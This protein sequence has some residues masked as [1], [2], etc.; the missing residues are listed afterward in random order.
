M[1]LTTPPARQ[2]LDTQ[3]IL[4]TGAQESFSQPVQL[5]FSDFQSRLRE[6]KISFPKLVTKTVSEENLLGEGKEAYVYEI[7]GIE[8]YVLRVTH[9]KLNKELDMYEDNHPSMDYAQ[10]I[11]G[12]YHFSPLTAAAD[13][14]PHLNVGQA[15]GKSK[16]IK[17]LKKQAGIELELPYINDQ[18]KRREAHIWLCKQLANLP[19]ESYIEFWTNIKTLDELKATYDT[20]HTNILLD[21]E[22]K[23][24]N[25][26][27]VDLE[28]KRKD[29]FKLSFIHLL[30]AVMDRL[31]EQLKNDKDLQSLHKIILD[32]CIQAN[33]QVGVPVMLDQPRIDDFLQQAGV[34]R[35]YLRLHLNT[36]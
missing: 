11:G 28:K 9:G 8:H 18:Q 1:S 26:V 23:R 12:N 13:P 16:G 17:V 6:L 20:E 5:S 24:L 21:E 30:D 7:P 15:V 31:G 3:Q 35:N 19:L 27:D 34:D 32:K 4:T 29:G 10:L 36:Q 2:R 14:L 22:E 33:N 25:L